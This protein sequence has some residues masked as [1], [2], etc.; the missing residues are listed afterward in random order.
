MDLKIEADTVKAG[1]TLDV[2][3]KKVAAK[4]GAASPGKN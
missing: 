4:G 2:A 1:G 3:L